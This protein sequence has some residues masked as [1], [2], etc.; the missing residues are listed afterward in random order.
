MLRA[1]W[2]GRKG[3]DN[4]NAIWSGKHIIP[5][6][7]ARGH[8]VTGLVRSSASAT[9]I[10]SLGPSVV[11]VIGD[12]SDHELLITHAKAND[13]VI[14]CAFDHRSDIEAQAQVEQKV[15]QLFGDALEGSNKVLI[16]S[17]GT[18]FLKPGSD[19]SSTATESKM[20]RSKIEGIV[21]GFKDR[22]IRAISMRLA[23]NTHSP[24]LMHPF[25]GLLIGAADKFGFIPYLP[26]RHWSACNADDAGLLYVLAMES[27]EPG[28]ALHGVQEILPL[29]VI[30]EALG[31]KVGK[32]VGEVPQD[33]L[34]SLGFFGFLL[35]VNQ[36]FST[37]W[38][39]ETFGWEPKGQ[40]LL[41]EIAAA[42]ADYF[43]QNDGKFGSS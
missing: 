1:A 41:D 24:D 5:H 26:K 33:Q 40:K 18:A 35:T 25:L 7:L 43:G 31:K 16:M 34:G 10:K 15:L 6:L 23:M 20:T 3:C 27:A 37:K 12:V 39:R 14:H 29:K 8:S 36:D 28:K 21:L 19:E 9:L 32:P 42:P 4:A 11:A 22:G 30:A 13:A 38:T 17:T 2:V